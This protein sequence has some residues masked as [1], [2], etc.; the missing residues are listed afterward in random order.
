[1]GL[2]ALQVRIHK[3]RPGSARVRRPKG[4]AYQTL[5]SLAILAVFTFQTYVT[6][7][8][9]HHES[10]S[11][12][13]ISAAIDTASDTKTRATATHAREHGRSV[14]ADDPAHC[15]ICQEFLTAGHY[16]APAPVAALP[17]V[18]TVTFVAIIRDVPIAYVPIAHDWR[19]RAP[20]RA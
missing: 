12:P 3:S 7:T 14:P 17:L 8:H 16:V 4:V 19:G 2:A 20:P 11:D 1:M 10:P 15:P 6:Q 5:L 18:L 13:R 9:I